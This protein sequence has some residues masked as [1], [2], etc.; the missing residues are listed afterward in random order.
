MVS[1]ELWDLLLRHRIYILAL[2]DPGQLG[3]VRAADDLGLLK[4]PHVFLDEI[5]RQAEGNE[6]IKLSMNIRYGMPLMNFQGNHVQ[7]IN[8]DELS[9]GMLTWAD[10]ILCAKNETRFQLNKQLREINGHTSE[11]EIGDKII[12]LKNYWDEISLEQATPLVNG[13]LGY[14][15]AVKKQFN[16]VANCEVLKMSFVSELGET[17]EDL[18]I[19]YKL[20]MYNTPSLTRAD[21]GR[22]SRNS[23][24]ARNIPKEFAFGY[25]ITTWKAQGSEWDNILLL[26]EAFPYA[27]DEHKRYLYT[28]VTR[29]SQ[30]IVVVKK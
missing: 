2:G 4:K 18:I 3:P 1:K 22:M 16:T 23:L 28:G 26:E 7:I 19:D 6:I 15:T 9:T 29:A 11:P 30:K 20:L 27:A 13:T 24:N 21:F 5:M 12:C 14:I 10:Q 8:K 25:A 17:Y